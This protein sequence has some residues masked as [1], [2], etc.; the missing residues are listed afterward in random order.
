MGDDKTQE[1]IDGDSPHAALYIR[2]VTIFDQRTE[3]SPSTLS[4]VFQNP[5]S[6]GQGAPLRPSETPRRA[7][8][9]ELCLPEKGIGKGEVL[10]AQEVQ[11]SICLTFH[12]LVDCLH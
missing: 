1:L 10:L 2:D 3:G 4:Q 11:Y 7:A 6:I 8:L 9:G 5:A 12:C